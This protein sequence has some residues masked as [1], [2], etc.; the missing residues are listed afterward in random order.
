MDDGK[1]MVGD[2]DGD[3]EGTDLGLTVVINFY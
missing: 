3:E 2:D 1:R